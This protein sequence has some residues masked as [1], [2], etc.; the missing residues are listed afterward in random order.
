MV[1]RTLNMVCHAI[2]GVAYRPAAVPAAGEVAGDHEIDIAGGVAVPA[3]ERSPH[4]QVLT[5]EGR[6]SC[7]A[8]LACSVL[9]QS[10]SS[11]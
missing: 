4:G 7:R 10:C 1:V 3:Q 11:S 2:D 9:A 8:P 6:H 5:Q